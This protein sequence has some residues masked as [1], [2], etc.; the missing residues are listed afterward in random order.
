MI[1]ASIAGGKGETAKVTQP[2][3][4]R[5]SIGARANGEENS[6]CLSP[7]LGLA[8]SSDL[9]EFGNRI[10]VRVLA[11]LFPLDPL[12]DLFA[13][14]GNILRSVDADSDLIALDP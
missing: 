2:R 4:E 9:R 13:V 11:L 12:V 14:Y 5:R 10:R 3:R 6:K 7:I 1:L 8:P